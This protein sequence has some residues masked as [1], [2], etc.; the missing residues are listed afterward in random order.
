[1]VRKAL[2]G[3]ESPGEKIAAWYS[4]LETGKGRIPASPAVPTKIK[5]ETREETM[6]KEK[7]GGWITD[8]HG[9]EW[10]LGGHK[11]GD[12]L[13]VGAGKVLRQGSQTSHNVVNLG[14][15][16]ANR[17]REPGMRERPGR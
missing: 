4:V 1:M 10:K 12:S 11:I 7:R 17:G 13:H 3:K 15:D 16:I 2:G 6:S 9:R 14:R 5:K 8:G